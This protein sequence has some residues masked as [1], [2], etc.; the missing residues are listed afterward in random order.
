MKESLDT[1][2]YK[3]INI[4]IIGYLPEICGTTNKL[5]GTLYLGQGISGF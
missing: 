5:V 3:N 2:W 1:G 4:Y